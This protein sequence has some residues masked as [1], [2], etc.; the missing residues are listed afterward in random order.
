MTSKHSSPLRLA[1]AAVAAVVL[2]TA[3]PVWADGTAASPGPTYRLTLVA[4]GRADAVYFSAWDNGPVIA[5]VSPR[6]GQPL[7]YRRDFRWSD[8][9][10]W[11]AVERLTPDG[12]RYL[13][14]Y[15]EH[16]VACPSERK[17]KGTPSPRTG[18]VLVEQLPPADPRE[19]TPLTGVAAS[20]SLAD[21]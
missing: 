4:P 9:C 18:H 15:N 14:R 1:V 2:A 6:S 8:G 19:L 21:E 5:D 10:L 12:D 3:C 7:V 13:Y 20:S 16:V 17:A 11:Q